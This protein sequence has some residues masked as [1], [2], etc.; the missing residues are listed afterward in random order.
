MDKF[1]PLEAVDGVVLEDEA[2]ASLDDKTC[3]KLIAQDKLES[4]K[5]KDA[6]FRRPA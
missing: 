3:E 5:V 2:L 4:E 6:F 1:K